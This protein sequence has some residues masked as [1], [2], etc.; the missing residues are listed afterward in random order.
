MCVCVCIY[1]YV[2]VYLYVRR[3]ICT[4]IH[5]H[6]CIYSLIHFTQNTLWPLLFTIGLVSSHILYAA[7]M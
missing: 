1:D 2:C 3:Y 4:C 7:C 5:T 6:I